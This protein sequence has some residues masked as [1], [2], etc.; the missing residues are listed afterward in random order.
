MDPERNF[1][2]EVRQLE[3]SRGAYQRLH[4]V[5]RIKDEWG[6]QLF[7]E[8]WAALTSPIKDSL[9]DSLS[10]KE[11]F[12]IKEFIA[13]CIRNPIAPG[14]RELIIS[15]IIKFFGLH[16]LVPSVIEVYDKVSVNLQRE[17][18]WFLLNVGTGQALRFLKGLVETSAP[19][20][21]Q[22]PII[23]AGLQNWLQDKS[24]LL[25]RLI[26]YFHGYYKPVDEWDLNAWLTQFGKPADQ[27]L[28]LHLLNHVRFINQEAIGRASNDLWN[29]LSRDDQRNAFITGLG[30]LAK[31]GTH[32][33]YEFRPENKFNRKKQIS[34]LPSIL[35]TE[36]PD[37]LVIVFIDDMIGS[38]RQAVR[39]YNDLLKQQDGAIKLM[40][41]E[42]ERLKRAMKYF[43]AVIGFENG[44]NFVRK[45]NIFQKV[46]VSITLREADKA[47]SPEAG[48]FDNLEDLRIAMQIAKFYGSYLYPSL[49]D[50]EPSTGQGPLGFE[51]CQ[52][53]VVF[54]YNTPNNTLPI[55]WQT[56]RVKSKDWLALFP[57]RE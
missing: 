5:I 7:I 55:L 48:I 45:A 30:P 39:F 53:L 41:S 49:R 38:G 9:L 14:D 26:E 8:Q 51:D 23:I 28:M 57:R 40:P 52:A 34:D 19:I 22:Q 18:Q 44:I 37:P 27:V 13:N 4:R 6:I 43:L 17:I 36:K 50:A 31:S 12:Q 32:I 46:S 11:A 25:D 20:G 29:S 16:C 35:R 54:Y 42:I 24:L 47:F 1:L 21:V 33:L 3:E 56:G 15:H 10:F 2:D